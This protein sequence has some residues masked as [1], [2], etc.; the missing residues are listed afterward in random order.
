MYTAL[1]CVL[2][3]RGNARHVI[4]VLY[5]WS[6]TLS[7]SGTSRRYQPRRSV[8]FKLS[9]SLRNEKRAA[10]VDRLVLMKWDGRVDS[11]KRKTP[12][13]GLARVR[14]YNFPSTLSTFLADY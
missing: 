5:M 11:V 3:S 8:F 4:A 1:T 10:I 6:P 9:I 12:H 7:G 14:V 13:A 2:S